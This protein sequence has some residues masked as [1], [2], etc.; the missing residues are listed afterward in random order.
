MTL[1][2]LLASTLG[3]LWWYLEHHKGA[4]APPPQPQGDDNTVWTDDLI[5]T[6]RNQR[7][8]GQITPDQYDALLGKYCHSYGREHGKLGLCKSDTVGPNQIISDLAE[9]DRLVAAA[10]AN[11]K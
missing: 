8:N 6:Y 11:K 2:V 5:T 9:W 7:V 10:S 1:A 3:F 4:S